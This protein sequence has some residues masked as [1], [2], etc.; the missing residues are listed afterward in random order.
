MTE[1][2]RLLDEHAGDLEEALLRSLH[3]DAPSAQARRRTLGALGALVAA[4][5]VSGG[6]SAAS[7]T[8]GVARAAG[9]RVLS[10]L[11]WLAV[12]A[13]F[14]VC[15]A[16]APQLFEAI[17]A[18]GRA[19][20][21]RQPKASASLAMTTTPSAAMADVGSDNAAQ[22]ARGVLGSR[23]LPIAGASIAQ[24]RPSAGPAPAFDTDSAPEQSSREAR[25][26]SSIAAELA[27]LD[28]ARR[29]LSDG[30]SQ[31]A[32]E[33]LDRFQRQFPAGALREE[34]LVLRV[35]S[36]IQA[37]QRAAGIALG[38]EYMSTYPHGPHQSKIEALIDERR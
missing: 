21:A 15:L 11:K 34:A 1:P 28:A 25:N 2:S 38:R 4:S 12:G 16:S 36:L 14:G 37:G 31:L 20:L 35:S 9:V 23:G 24:A 26:S 33:R 32:L 8:H 17:A 6:I 5:S 18:P 10:V 22:S 3:A 30:N 27:L 29:A 13:G 19:A 7:A